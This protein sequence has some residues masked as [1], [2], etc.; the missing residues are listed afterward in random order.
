[1]AV[2]I[3]QYSVAVPLR[4]VD[5]QELRRFGLSGSVPDRAA[6]AD[7][8]EDALT[9]AAAAL[10]S[11]V[12]DPERTTTLC[13]GSTTLPYS[14]RIQSGLLA[15]IAGV[16]PRL[17]VTEH[18]TSFRAGTEALLSAAAL[19]GSGRPDAQALVLAAEMPP[20]GR[21]DTSLSPGAAAFVL[22][23]GGEAAKLEGWTSHVTEAPGLSFIP[24]GE[25]REHDIGVPGYAQDVIL[26]TIVPAAREVLAQ[27][28]WQP[29]DVDRVVLNLA[30]QRTAQAVLKQLRID[31]ERWRGTWIFP[32]F[33]DTGAAA[34]L[35]GLAAALDQS[36][37]GARILLLSYGSG[38]AVD[39]MAW[40]AGEG[41]RQ[42]AVAQAVAGGTQVSV[43]EYMRL[44]GVI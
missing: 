1:M 10:S 15:A 40:T 30:D 41:A 25:T 36:P 33:G 17:V 4:F 8:D 20:A 31:P 39:A 22:G 11:V 13:L 32:Q 23:S 19:I 9:L 6:V 5:G 34:A 38:S 37:A 21:A 7:A 26:S 2:T 3:S 27:A 12:V 28:G 43:G 16:G 35:V 24:A 29:G 14:R 44:R 18:T 42:G